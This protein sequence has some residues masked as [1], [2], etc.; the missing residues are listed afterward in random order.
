MVRFGV[1]RKK[2]I[3]SNLPKRAKPKLVKRQNVSSPEKGKGTSVSFRK[4]R[5]MQC[6]Q[7][8][9]RRVCLG[10]SL[11]DIARFIQNECGE[12][13]DVTLASLKL[14]LSNYRKALPPG[15]LISK[16]MPVEHKR[17]LDA[18]EQ[19]ID[20]VKEL[21]KLFWIQMERVNIDL[22]R[23]R[24]YKQLT[25]TMN[26]EM[27]TAREIL[28]SLAE[29]K[30]DLGLQKRHLGAVE[31]ENVSAVVMARFGDEKIAAVFA[32][33]EKRQRLLGLAKALASREV[34]PPVIDVQPQPDTGPV[35][36]PLEAM[37]EVL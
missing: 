23:E 15:E 28:S 31:G 29:L 35:A 17:A 1:P 32:N 37:A 36:D 27:R 9:H 24:Q 5:A 12:Y 21:E 13:K 30:M 18:V 22:A 4:L 14:Q 19:G 10:L 20:E 2:P 6:Y 34:T 11:W 8:V 7:E 16:R 33:S 25:P 3:T 26:Q